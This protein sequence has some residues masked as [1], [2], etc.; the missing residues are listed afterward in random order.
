M[1]VLASV[2][3]LFLGLALA[4]GLFA[5]FDAVGFTLPNSGS[6][7]RPARSIVA[8]LVGILVTVVASLRPALR[9]TRVPPIA[10]VREGPSCRSG[11]F[12][13]FRT[14]RLGRSLGRSASRRSSRAVRAPASAPRS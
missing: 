4:K 8:L 5:L 2:A 11:G 14:L 6:C 1:G 13:R 9:A 10:A 7:S 3:G 12:Q